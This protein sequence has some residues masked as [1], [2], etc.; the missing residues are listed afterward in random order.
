MFQF[1]EKLSFRVPIYNMKITSFVITI[2][3]DKA[4]KE[5]KKRN[6]ACRKTCRLS[7]DAYFYYFVHLERD[8]KLLNSNRNRAIHSVYNI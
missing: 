5:H 7:Y 1:I 4:Q 2:T 8:D 3:Y 6:T